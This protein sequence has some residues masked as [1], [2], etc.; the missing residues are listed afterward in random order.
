M[1]RPLTFVR[2]LNIPTEIDGWDLVRERAITSLKYQNCIVCYLLYTRVS[3][4]ISSVTTLRA[5]RQF[6]FGTYFVQK[7]NQF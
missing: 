6:C 3:K 7:K 1:K 5:L 2:T 4:I